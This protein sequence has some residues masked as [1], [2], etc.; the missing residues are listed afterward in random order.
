MFRNMKVIVVGSVLVMAGISLI[1]VL[2]SIFFSANS[3]VTGLVANLQGGGC[4]V[5]NAGTAFNSL[6]QTKINTVN[7]GP[8]T[9]NTCLLYTSPS[10]RDS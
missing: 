3:G 8:N 9:P 5:E 4:K 1:A 10:P 7:T 6:A 2:I